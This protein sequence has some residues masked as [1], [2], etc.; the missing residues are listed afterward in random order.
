MEDQLAEE[1]EGGDDLRICKI[2]K[3]G[4]GDYLWAQHGCLALRTTNIIF[5]SYRYTT[6][7]FIHVT[8]ALG[9][10]SC[11]GGQYARP[12]LDLSYRGT[13]IPC[14]MHLDLSML[15]LCILTWPGDP[16]P[17]PQMDSKSSLEEIS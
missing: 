12:R 13:S 3:R 1:A 9:L 6:A 14:I 8:S 7:I 17:W 5:G 16:Y 15:E 4:V 10:P 11:S 2:A